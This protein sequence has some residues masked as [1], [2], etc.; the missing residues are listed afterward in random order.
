MPEQISSQIDPA[1][2]A[3]WLLEQ[4]AQGGGLLPER[5]RVGAAPFG[6]PYLP[7]LPSR[8]QISSTNTPMG[9]RYAEQFNSPTLGKLM[10]GL[11][12]AGT[13]GRDFAMAGNDKMNEGARHLAEADDPMKVAGG[14]GEMVHGG[15]MMAPGVGPASR[16]FSSVPRAMGTGAAFGLAPMA[17]T[18]AFSEGGLF[19]NPAEAASL[20][21]KQERAL[22]ETRQ[23]FK[24]ETEAKTEAAKQAAQTERDKLAADEKAAQQR[25]IEAAQR[26][27]RERNPEL[28]SNWPWI[29]PVSAAGGAL[30]AKA[31]EKFAGYIANR[32][33]WQTVRAAQSGI[34]SNDAAK[35][36]PA[37]AE[38]R[39]RNATYNPE[40]KSGSALPALAGMSLGGELGMLPIQSDIMNMG[41]SKA[42]DN[43]W[44]LAKAG[45]TA[46]M[47][48]LS[49]YTAGKFGQAAIPG[50][51]PPIEASR[52]L[53]GKDVRSL[54]TVPSRAPPQPQ[55]APIP[56]APQPIAP[57]TPVA[58]PVAPV[59]TNPQ[60]SLS[61]LTA[62]QPQT[63]PVLAPP[64]NTTLADPPAPLSLAP[65][66]RP[67]GGTHPDHEWN[68]KV[69]RWQ[70]AKG[71][72]LKGGAPPDLD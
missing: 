41:F 10:S 50:S 17:A 72:F 46:G 30:V 56:L 9:D 71:R 60:Q 52:A 24:I 22:E 16:L 39:Q 57:P 37:I 62:P 19:S 44:E 68:A 33:W 31:G 63:L 3:Q 7:P 58:P 5:P 25:K 61:Q 18:G 66:P 64:P 27:W 55:Q 69:G 11:D 2:F 48:A 36:L 32:P 20:T 28:A 54:V 45:L 1:L 67:I 34:A 6:L 29:V 26:P 43:P 15:V 70:D 38:L 21:K 23:R 4:Q 59:A 13:I 65:R 53:A 8:D 51:Q 47:G 42:I 12:R 40:T 35:A 14:L 49:G